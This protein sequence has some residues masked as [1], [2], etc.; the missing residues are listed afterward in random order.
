MLGWKSALGR[1]SILE[2]ITL[3]GEARI[4]EAC[5][6]ISVD[7]NVSV[8]SKYWRVNLLPFLTNLCEAKSEIAAWIYRYKIA[9]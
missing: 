9:Q 1:F 3:W 7:G 2:E 8:G 4:W 6:A 5:E